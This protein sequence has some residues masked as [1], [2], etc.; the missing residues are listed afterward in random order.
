LEIFIDPPRD[1]VGPV[2]GI[3]IDTP[4]RNF[5]QQVRVYASSDSRIG[6]RSARDGD[7]R[8]FAVVDVRNVQVP[9]TRPRIAISPVDRQC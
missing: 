4:L 2:D 6:G 1:Q 5:E 8:L 7:F 3:S 9:I